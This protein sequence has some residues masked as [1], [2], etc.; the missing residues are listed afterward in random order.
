M[1]FGAG[2][3]T[4]FPDSPG[5]DPN[6][7]TLETYE[8]AAADYAAR[9]VGPGRPVVAFLDRLAELV[10]NGCVL[11]LGSGPG[12]DAD[13]LEGK[14]LRVI[15]T[16]AAASFVA[17]MRSEGHDA[18]RLDLR[19]D[20]F[21]GPHDAVLADAVLLHLT[22]DQLESVLRRL[23][24]AV[25]DGGLLA[26]TVKKGAGAG[27]STDKLGLPRY[28]AYWQ[29]GAVRELL[30]KAGWTVCSLQHSTEPLDEW[31]QVIAR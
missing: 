15:R 1:V 27:W 13:Y 10:G 21:G 6:D 19:T 9:E 25:R 4:D 26:F 3:S 7:V 16:D 23:R 14:G 29:E 2:D 17:M 22:R 5:R 31:L 30:T 8:A 28:F 18:R 12:R 20:A 24:A 11:E